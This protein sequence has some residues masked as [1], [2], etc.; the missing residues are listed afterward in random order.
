MAHSLQAESVVAESWCKLVSILG[1]AGLHCVYSQCLSYFLL[2][3]H[4]PWP[5]TLIKESINWHGQLQRVS[6]HDRDMA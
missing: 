5:E 1:I 2:T 6:V 3:G 4:T